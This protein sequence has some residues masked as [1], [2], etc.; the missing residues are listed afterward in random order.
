[1]I[2]NFNICDEIFRHI[3]HLFLLSLYSCG[4][5]EGAIESKS[6]IIRP[7]DSDPLAE[8]YVLPFHSNILRQ[9]IET[10]WN[11][12]SRSLATDNCT[13]SDSLTSRRR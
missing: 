5:C 8:E 7:R 1:M 12:I 3:Y 9:S 13:S 2:L 4:N 11:D 10:D 6:Q